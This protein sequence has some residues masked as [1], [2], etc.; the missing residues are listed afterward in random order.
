MELKKFIINGKEL[1]YRNS[2]ENVLIPVE[3]KEKD[4]YFR[5]AWVTSICNDFVHSTD[6][7]TMKM[8]LLKVLDY[9]N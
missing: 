6:K 7:E 1:K 8:N 4:S 3:Y 2:E 5:G 9:L